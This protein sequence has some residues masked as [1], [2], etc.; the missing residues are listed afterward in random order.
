MALGFVETQVNEGTV[1]DAV[2]ALYA[3]NGI[4]ETN[5]IS[6]IIKENNGQPRIYVVYVAPSE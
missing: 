2:L 3:A 5:H 6:T 4:N 1:A